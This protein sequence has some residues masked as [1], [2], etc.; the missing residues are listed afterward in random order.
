MKNEIVNQHLHY[1]F[2]LKIHKFLM[3]YIWFHYII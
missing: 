1:S 3:P 2:L